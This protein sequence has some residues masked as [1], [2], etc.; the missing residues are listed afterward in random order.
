MTDNLQSALGLDSLRSSHPIEVPVHK[1]DEINQIFDAISYSKGS[2]VLRMISSHIGEPVFMEGVRQYLKKHAYGNTVTGDLWAALSTA[3]GTNVQDVMTTWTKH[4]GYPVITVTEDEKA[5]SITVKQNRFLRTGDTKP[6]EDKVIYPV[7]LGIRTKDGV[8]ESLVLD[9]REGT[10]ELPSLDFFKLNANHTNIYRTAYS[11]ERLRKLG[12]AAR[13]GLLTVEDRAG[14]LADAG[15]LSQSGY[16]KTTGLLSL[17]KGFSGESEYVVW[18]EI[19]ARLSG[20]QGVWLF[21][22]KEVRDGLELFQR[23]LVSAKAHELG[24][25]FSEDDGH[26][27]QQFKALLFGAAGISGDQKIVAAAKEMFNKY[28]AGDKT[29]LHPNIRGS[30]FAM[31]LKHGGKA[32]VSHSI[33]IILATSQWP[34]DPVWRLT[35]E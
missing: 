31:T 1:A 21:E 16:Q 25:E 33:S 14:M 20:L 29:A 28:M 2:C 32:E 15:A 10:F 27:L 6:E 17:L 18:S 3:S 5:S 26:I 13:D 7:F 11:A 35:T 30:V 22:N 4:V 8:N 23:S 24:W 12:A 9:K 34:H 19:I